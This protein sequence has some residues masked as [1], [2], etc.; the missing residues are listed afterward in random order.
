M[1][2]RETIV[3][4]TI[5]FWRWEIQEPPGIDPTYGLVSRGVS[6]EIRP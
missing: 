2:K 3:V 1:V 6:V 5:I 4:K